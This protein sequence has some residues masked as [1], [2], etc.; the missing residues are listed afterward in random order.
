MCLFPLAPW[1]ARMGLVYF[2]MGIF[3]LMLGLTALRYALFVAVW[4]LTGHAFWLFPNMMEDQVCCSALHHGKCGTHL[5]QL[6][7]TCRGIRS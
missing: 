4:V 6:Q 5:Q 2:L 7:S 1:W 3:A